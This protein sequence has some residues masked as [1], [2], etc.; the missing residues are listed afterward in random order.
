MINEYRYEVKFVLSEAALSGFLSWLYLNTNCRKRYKDRQVNSIYF[1]DIGYSSVKDNLAG[2]PYRVKT[3]LRW[4]GDDGEVNTPVLEQKIKKGRLGSKT[5]APIHSLDK[6][7]FRL[8]YSEIL[9][10]IAR[11]SP[12]GHL[13][14]IEYLTPALGVSYSRQYFEDYNGLRITIDSDIQFDGYLSMNQ[15]LKDKKRISYRNKIIEL[16]FHPEMK[17]YV[18]NLISSLNLTPVR[19]SKYL[20]GLAMFGQVQY[21]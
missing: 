14:T 21:I 7:M 3:R 2:I 4:Y 10:H 9:K 5:A 1:D 13:S 12:K 20:T 11:S 15:T 8:T 17:G 6:N 18:S 16:K 19:H